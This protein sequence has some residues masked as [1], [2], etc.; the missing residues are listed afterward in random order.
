MNHA[1][2]AAAMT[3]KA[4]PTPRPILSPFERKSSSAMSRPPSMGDG[5][6]VGFVAGAVA[7]WVWVC[8]GEVAVA[9]AEADAEEDGDGDGDGD[10]DG[11]GDG[12]DEASPATAARKASSG[13]VM[14]SPVPRQFS[15][16]CA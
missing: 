5:G 14:V 13:T 11:D 10:D 3:P 12:D 9:V 16:I 15:R 6:N 1:A 4:T 8:V 2:S 7:D